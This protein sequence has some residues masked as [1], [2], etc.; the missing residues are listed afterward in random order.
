MDILQNSTASHL[1]GNTKQTV[2]RFRIGTMTAGG[3]AVP[4]ED[5]LDL[6]PEYLDRIA[7]QGICESVQLRCGE[8]RRTQW[9]RGRQYSG[10]RR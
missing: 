5:R 3:H 10:T 4:L 9:F 6:A 1:G 8:P 7:R 2:T